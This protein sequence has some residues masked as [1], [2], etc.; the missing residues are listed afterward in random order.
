MGGPASSTTAE[1][2]MQAHECTAISTTLH[3]PKVCKLFV[4]DVFFILLFVH[5]WKTLSIP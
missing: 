4:D 1:S 5:T 3:P 2:Y